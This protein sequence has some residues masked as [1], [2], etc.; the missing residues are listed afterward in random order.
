[1]HCN[2][3]LLILEQSN[4][5]QSGVILGIWTCTICKGLKT[6]FQTSVHYSSSRIQKFYLY[7]THHPTIHTLVKRIYGAVT[8]PK[9]HSWSETLLCPHGN[10]EDFTHKSI[11]FLKYKSI[12]SWIQIHRILKTN[13]EDQ[14]NNWTK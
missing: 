12:G 10:P 3:G 5:N 13:P 11:V 4:I 6:S 9:Q 2:F 14:L 7:K 1:M 8:H